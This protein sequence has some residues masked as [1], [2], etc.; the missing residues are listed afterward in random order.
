MLK[1][2]MQKRHVITLITLALGA[3]TALGDLA[4]YDRKI[5]SDNVGG[6]PYAA[7]STTTMTFDSTNSEAFDFGT[8]SESATMEFIV[9]G[10]PAAGGG[11]GYLAN[12]SNTGFSLRYEQWND[13]GRLGFTQTGV[14][15]YLFTAG[16][17]PPSAPLTDSPTELTHVTYRWDQ[18][19]T[20]LDLYIN[21]I[22]VGTNKSAATFEMPTGE[23]F[24][25]NNVNLN[26]GMAGT[27]ERVTVYNEAVDPSTI[28]THSEAWR[29][30]GGS[31]ANYDSV[32]ASDNA[33]A[34][35]YTAI[36]SS[37][38]MFDTTNAEPFD[39]GTISESATIEFIVIGD[40]VTTESNGFLAT[41]ANS[42]FS[43]RY[44]QWNNTGKL[45][46]SQAR[47]ADYVFLPVIIE[48]P[49]GP[50]LDSPTEPTHITYRWDQATTT[51]ELY[52][53]GV[54]AGNN[55][56]ATNFEM[57]TGLGVLGNNPGFSEGMIGTLE[58][59]TVYNEAISVD[60][61]VAH[62]NAWLGVQALLLE[63]SLSGNELTL[64]WESQAGKIYDLLSSP[65]LASNP[66][67]W[68]VYDGLQD[69]EATPPLNTLMIELP[70]DPLLFFVV[71]ER[72]APPLFED[73][74]E[75]DKNWL[76]GVND[77]NNNTEWQRGMPTTVGPITGADDSANCFATNIADNYGA[78]ANVFLRSPIIDLTGDGL[79]GAQLTYQQVIDTDLNGAD[80]GII[81][82][83]S[84]DGTTQ[85]G[86]DVAGPFEGDSLEWSKLSFPLPPEAIGNMIR[87]EFEFKSDGTD[88][89]SGWYIDNVVVTGN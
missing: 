16:D 18:A 45:G 57:P 42:T 66:S 3:S 6:L 74:F 37:T 13:T 26:A 5:T 69:I 56:A 21:G 77:S 84:S 28:L 35:P 43:V 12:G 54:L 4:S 46:F 23:G 44:E 71:Q 7:I 47:V 25:G 38:L 70:A 58:R 88:Q 75:T 24:L 1:P 10:D 62:A 32:I 8:V 51:M 61:I 2:K 82:V 73:D 65:D 33:G 80:I 59:V 11:D 64:S 31:L 68:P 86:A 81:R 22:R 41:G 87:I 27:M 36:V 63:I 9:S 40:P 39:F 67:T 78:D 89:F 52:V 55:T 49:D 29:G 30:A 14:A 76:T 53:D 48:D 79:T 20:T 50:S 83:L 15:D 34:L 72:P 60:S 85:L 19:T 17:P